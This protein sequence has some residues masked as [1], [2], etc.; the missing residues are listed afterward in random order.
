M[1]GLC[2]TKGVEK[3]LE[4]WVRACGV[5]LRVRGRWMG[6]YMMEATKAENAFVI[7]LGP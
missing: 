2:Q 1:E 7:M 5:W 3:A 4:Q 6:G